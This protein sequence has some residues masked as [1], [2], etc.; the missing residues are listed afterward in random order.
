M[1]YLFKLILERLYK[2]PKLLVTC[3]ITPYV[4]V[5]V[6]YVRKMCVGS[7]GN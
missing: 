1:L 7:S 6:I 4:F 2:N 3:N 5:L